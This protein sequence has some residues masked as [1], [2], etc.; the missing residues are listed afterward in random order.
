MK[1]NRLHL[2][3][4]RGVGELVLDLQGKSAIL[5]GIN[6]VG[7]STIL[8]AVNLLYVP[9]LNKLTRQKIKQPGNIKLSD[10]RTGKASADIS[11]EFMFAEDGQ[12]LPFGR[13]ITY[14]NRRI[15]NNGQLERLVE[16]Y[17]TLYVG[18]QWVDENNDLMADD[19]E[20]NIPI[21]V[22][23]GVNRLVLKT[24]LRFRKRPSYGRF[25]AFEKA[26]ED[27]IAF[28]R[29][30]E[31]F[32]DQEYFE[33]KMQKE[34]PDYR[35]KELTAVKT[36]MLAMLDDCEDIH[37]VAKPYS[38]RITKDGEDLDILQLS[39]GEKCTLALFGDIARRLAQANPSL[40]DPLK[41]KGVVLIDE[42][43]LHCS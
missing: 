18:R 36:A 31:W 8:S 3:D 37:I 12:V 11:A 42:L 27:Q 40:E 39:D 25:E 10:I 30:F 17:E 32:F 35:D 23:Y 2:S 14:E 9:I 20:H 7:K 28:D 26:I 1:I 22:N 19:Q 33:I 34:D 43:E 15:S 4:F 29:L 16:H 13:G 38:M 5:F 24:P 41:G 21:F 6:G